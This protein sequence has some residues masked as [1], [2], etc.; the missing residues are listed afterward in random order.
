MKKH[1]DLAR[2]ADG[3][4]CH[5]GNLVFIALDNLRHRSRADGGRGVQVR[6]G[7]P[8]GGASFA[9]ISGLSSSIPSIHPMAGFQ[10]G[11]TAAGRAEHIARGVP[12][13]PFCIYRKQC[14]DFWRAS[15]VYKFTKKSPGG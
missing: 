10:A 2:V 9:N 5:S 4:L 12:A 1:L 13:Q 11:G 15:T 8:H 14:Y 6:H 7:T 3:F